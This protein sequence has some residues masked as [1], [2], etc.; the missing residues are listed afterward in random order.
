MKELLSKFPSATKA[1]KEFYFEKLMRSFEKNNNVPDDF[2]EYARQKG[3]TDENF[4]NL[5]DAAPGQSFDLFDS[6]NIY[7]EIG[8]VDGEGGFRWRING[9][10]WSRSYSTRIEAE[11]P[12][13]EEAYEKLENKL[14][15]G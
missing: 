4:A 13:V 7:I 3:I 9:G 1:A 2:K 11:W 6:Y 10:D 12:A 5:L 14:N 15:E 8:V